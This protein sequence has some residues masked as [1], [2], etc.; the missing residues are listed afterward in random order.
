MSN[1][2]C[3]YATKDP[4]NNISHKPCTMSQGL[5]RSS[6]PHGYNHSQTRAYRSFSRAE[7][8]ADG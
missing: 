7:K 5:F 6:V 3:E 4:C 2:I 8:E 1:T